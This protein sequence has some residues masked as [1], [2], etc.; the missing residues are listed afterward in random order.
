MVNLNNFSWCSLISSSA[1][2][3]LSQILF[4]FFLS[5]SFIVC[6]SSRIFPSVLNAWFLFVE[7]LF[8]FMYFA[9]LFYLSLLTCTSLNFNEMLENK[10]MLY[11]HCHASLMIC[12]WF[13]NSL[14][15]GENQLLKL[16]FNI[17]H[18]YTHAQTLTLTLTFTHTHTY[19]QTY[20]HTLHSI[21]INLNEQMSHSYQY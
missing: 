9:E 14:V 7:F 15:E 12:V 17:T 10:E 4:W 8:L 6:H 2:P 1:W 21:M 16:S 3:Y 20:S 18:L 5:Q 13:L 11:S 19:R